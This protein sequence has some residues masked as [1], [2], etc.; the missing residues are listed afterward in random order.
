MYVGMVTCMD[1]EIG[2][3]VDVLRQRNIWKNTILIFS[4]GNICTFF[5][6]NKDIKSLNFICLIYKP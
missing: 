1:E 6:W 2:N 3:I 5:F 4:T